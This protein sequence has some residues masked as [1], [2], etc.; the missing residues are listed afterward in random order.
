MPR[1]ET[2]RLNRVLKNSDAPTRRL[3]ALLKTQHLRYA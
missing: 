2:Q 3:K 1:R